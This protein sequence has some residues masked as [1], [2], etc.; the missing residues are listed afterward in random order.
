MDRV[1]KVFYNKQLAAILKKTE[2]G[3]YFNYDS[4]YIKNGGLSLSF[5]LPLESSPIY[6]ATLFAFFE[7]LVSEGW[8]LNL[9]SRIQKIDKSDKFSLILENGKDLVGAVTIEEF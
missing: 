1:A 3:F 9:Q 5:S 7:N 8:L 4:F 6:S 2:N